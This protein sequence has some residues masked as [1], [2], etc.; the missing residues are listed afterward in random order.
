MSTYHFHLNGEWRGGLHG[1]G[2][3]EAG[4]LKSSISVPKEFRGPGI[5]TNPEEMLIGSAATCYIITLASRLEKNNIS[6]SHLSIQTEGVLTKVG[7]L[8][9]TDIIH[10][11]KVLLV[12]TSTEEDVKKATAL[13]FEAEESCMISKAMRGNVEF[14]VEPT[15]IIQKENH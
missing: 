13:S 11:P 4:S 6:V 10:R 15:I 14:T 3:I 8:H 12:S 1:E 5:G 7:G 2:E 9:F